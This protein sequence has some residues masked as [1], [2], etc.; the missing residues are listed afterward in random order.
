M[1]HLV[2]L[3]VV[4]LLTAFA[5]LASAQPSTD[6]ISAVVQRADEKLVA[7][8]YEGAVADYRTALEMMG[9]NPSWEVLANYS[10]GLYK[11]ELLAE[12]A[13]AL[14]EADRRLPL[15]EPDHA[16]IKKMFAERMAEILPRIGQLGVIVEPDGAE[17]I[18]DGT[19]RGR[20]PLSDTIFVMP[21][22]SA[23]RAQL[24]G[25]EPAQ[26]EITIG[27]GETRDV[28]LSLRS[29]ALVQPPERL[30]PPDEGL[31]GTRLGIGIV[32]IGL[33][34]V[35]S[36][37]AVVLGVTAGDR[38]DSVAELQARADDEAGTATNSCGAGSPA[39]QTNTCAQLVDFVDERDTFR[40]AAVGVGVVGGVL[41][42]GGILT[43][44]LPTDDATET[45]V[46]L[47][48]SGATIRGTF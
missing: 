32:A 47:S 1:R 36:A 3:L 5:A 18:V 28:T 22:T 12:A 34:I 2:F 46:V 40:G 8:D 9:P 14:R 24:A 7:K 25:Y 13:T 19:S 10:H 23:V 42:I 20:A 26:E 39:L 43:L 29:V 33:G 38:A 35:G 4:T 6:A 48:P 16:S 11:T 15:S 45:G 41:L 44:A 17:V 31:S 21:G 37:A 27:A 30:P